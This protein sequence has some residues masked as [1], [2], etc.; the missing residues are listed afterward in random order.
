M[1]SCWKAADSINVGK[2]SRPWQFVSLA[3]EEE[4]IIASFHC[5]KIIDQ[6]YSNQFFWQ[7]SRYGDL[8]TSINYRQGN[9]SLVQTNLTLSFSRT[10]QGRGRKSFWL[11]DRSRSD[12]VKLKDSRRQS[13]SQ[14]ACNWHVIAL[15]EW[16]DGG[17]GSNQRSDGTGGLRGWA[18]G[19]IAFS[20]T[21]STRANF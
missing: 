15:G 18:L 2:T 19:G 4:L 16:Q 21:L 10:A 17:R 13:K 7:R 8:D 3:E 6:I 5:P 14:N 12:D 1:R 9:C 20:L 11:R